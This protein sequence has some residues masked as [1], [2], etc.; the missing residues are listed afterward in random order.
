MV[1]N[2]FHPLMASCPCALDVITKKQ[3]RLTDQTDNPLADVSRALMLMATQLIQT[4][5]GVGVPTIT[6]TA[7]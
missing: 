7:Q 4:M 3:T 6:R 2:R 1:V 5:H